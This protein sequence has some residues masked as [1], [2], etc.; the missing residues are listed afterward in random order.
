MLAILIMAL[1]AVA[2][3]AVDIGVLYTAR[4]SAQHAADAAAIA[5]AYTFTNAAAT[6]PDAAINAAIAVA[7]ETAILGQPVT[8]TAADI[9]VDEPNRRVTV[10]VP[11]MA[12]NGGAVA[13]YFAQVIGINTVDVLVQATAEAA[14]S[15]TA[16]RC[17]KPFF[18]PNTVLSGKDWPQACADGEVF[19]DDS[20]TLTAYA[21]SRVGQLS[22]IRP[23]NPENALEPGQFYSLDFGAGASTYECTIA[24]CLNYCP[25]VDEPIVRCNGEYPIKTGN[26]V[27]PT[28]Q[29]VGDFLA[30]PPDVWVSVGQYQDGA[31]GTV[32]DSSVQLAVAPIWD[33][34]KQQISPGYN[35]QK[36]KIVGFSEIFIQGMGGQGNQFV[37]AYLVNATS[38]A[39]AG[40]AGEGSEVGDNTGPL[41]VPVRLVQNPAP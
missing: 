39:G 31:S 18:I 17:L 37:Q 23:T 5:A 30:E 3:L 40:D 41:G 34:C 7:A 2:A 28:R 32:K 26:M 27:G 8:I 1:F 14:A 13:T 36:V 22:N 33:N 4:T 21:Q 35:G 25:N 20:G 9:M 38:C 6:Q 19:F 15:G 10:N 11:R 12:D 24:N 16:S 29:G